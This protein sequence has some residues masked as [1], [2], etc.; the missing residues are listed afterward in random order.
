MCNNLHQSTLTCGAWRICSRV[1][2][3]CDAR[4][5]RWGPSHAPRWRK[6]ARGNV[7]KALETAPAESRDQVRDLE[8]RRDDPGAGTASICAT[9]DHTH[10]NNKISTPQ[11]DVVRLT[12]DLKQVGGTRKISDVTVLEG[13]TPQSAGGASGSAGSSVPG[14]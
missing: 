1:R 10:V 9:V 6:V 13:A 7:R 2:L 5:L 11:T 12:A 14:Q 3:R 4:A 8:A